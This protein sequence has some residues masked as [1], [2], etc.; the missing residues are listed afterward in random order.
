MQH[1]I[2]TV[3]AGSTIAF[4]SPL[5]ARRRRTHPSLAHLLDRNAAAILAEWDRFAARLAPGHAPLEPQELRGHG[6]EV[7][8]TLA[9]AVELQSVDHS[10][11][12]TP[13]D[14][15]RSAAVVHAEARRQ[16]GFTVDAVIAEYRAL[17]ANVLALWREQGALGGKDAADVVR[18]D[19]AIDQAMADSMHWYMQQTRRATDLF[20]GIL[21]HDI[22]NPLGTIL[23]C[24]EY[25]VQSQLLTPAAAAPLLNA[26][27]R[28]R[29]IIDQ[30]ADFSRVQQQG[31]LPV[32]PVQGHLG[33]HLAR[34]VR[35]ARALHRTRQVSMHIEGDL[36]GQWDE[37]RLAQVLSNLLGNAFAY[38]AR[39]GD[40]TV[41][42]W[43][44]PTHGCFSVHNWGAPIA[45]AEQDRIFEPLVRG[46]A[47]ILERRGRQGLG[48]GLYICREI[49]RAHG[50][51]LSLR[52]N[53]ADGTTFEVR[54][55]RE[56]LRPASAMAALAPG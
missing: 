39:D 18:F 20:I 22:R 16:A 21:G 27:A 8:R 4:P 2:N 33:R 26:A 43:G 41:R 42:V 32:H 3:T 31:V 14:A 51:T 45:P 54:L 34:V 36:A 28:I 55:P 37:Q 19:E 49:V 23:S 9:S 40:V 5:A 17:R 44:T 12:T 24:A 13:S 30:T 1:V 15:T 35:E 50:G 48:L 38:G 47:A 56:R 10:A 6:P 29:G 25:F 52:S 53:A 7:L 46:H 11:D